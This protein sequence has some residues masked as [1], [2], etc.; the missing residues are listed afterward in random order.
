N[1]SISEQRVAF[2]DING[3]GYPD[4][5]I[6]GHNNAS[7]KAHLN[8]IDK[9]HLL[10]KINTPLGSGFEIDYERVGNTYNQPQS[11]WVFS[12]L[13][14]HDGFIADN[15]YGYDETLTTIIYEKGYHDR[16]ERDFYGFEKVRIEQRF[17]D[18][19]ALLYRY[20]VSEYHNKNYYLKGAVKKTTVYTG[21]EVVLNMSRSFYNLLDPESPTVNTNTNLDN[22]YLQVSEDKLDDSRIFPAI[23][24]TINTIYEGGQ[25]LDLVQEFKAYNSNGNITNY[26]NYGEGYQDAYKTIISYGTSLTY[27]AHPTT[28]E[29]YKNIGNQL[30]RKR[31]ANY[32]SLGQLQMITTH[33]GNNETNRISYEY[34][35][36][37]NVNKINQ[38]DNLNTA[39]AHF[40]QNIVYDSS[41]HTFPISFSDSFTQQS[42]ANYNYLFGTPVFIT[43]T[44]GNSIR[45]R[46]DNRGRVIEVTGPYELENNGWTIRKQYKD[47]GHVHQQ[48]GTAGANVYLIS[49]AKG[50]FKAVNPGA[51]QP[52]NAQHY[53]LTRHIDPS[54]NNNELL[55]L[56]IVDGNGQAIQLKKTHF[57]NSMKWMVNG[58]EEKDA[59]GRVV[60]SYLP[61]V[62]PSY[63]QNLYTLSSAHLSYFAQSPNSFPDPVEMQYDHRNRKISI[64]QPGEN[65]H[66]S[67][68]Y[69]IYNGMFTTLVT[70]E[71]GQTQ[72]SFTDLRG[73]NRKTIQNDEITTEFYYNTINELIKV[74]NTKGYETFYEYDLAGRRLTEKHPDRG[75]TK[76]SYNKIGLPLEKQ[77]SNLL[78]PEQTGVIEYKYHFHRLVEINYPHYP[79]NNVKY[80]YGINL[81][82]SEGAS[83]HIGRM[84][85]QE[86]AT[87]IQ[88]FKYGK[89]GEVIENLRSIAVAGKKSYWFKTQWE[90][91]SWNR[92]Q[93]ITYPDGEIVNYHYNLAGQLHGLARQINGINTPDIIK[94]IEYT[95]YGERAIVNYGNGTK[96]LYDYDLRRRMNNLEHQFTSFDIEKGY[97]YD[98]LSN[99]TSISTINAT[100]PTLGKLGGTINHSYNYDNYNRLVVA[101]GNYVGPGD[102][103]PDLLRH[104]YSLEMEYNESHSIISKK[105]YHVM[106]SIPSITGMISNPIPMLKTSYDLTYD[107]YATGG[108]VI[109][110]F[111][112]AQP[113]APRTI[114][115]YPN[116]DYDDDPT[117]LRIKHHSII[118]DANGNMLETKQRIADPNQPVGFEDKTIRKNLWDEEDR[119]R[120]VDLNPEADE[121]KPEVAVYTYDANGERSIKYTPGRVDSRYSAKETGHGKKLENIF[122]P[123]PLITV[124]ALPLPENPQV[125]LSIGNT[126]VKYTKHYYIGTER[127]NSAL[128]TYKNLGILCNTM[129]VSPQQIALMDQKV[130]DASEAL[131]ENYQKFDKI[132]EIGPAFLY[133]DKTFECRPAHDPKLY[134]SY[135]YHPDHTSTALSTGFGKFKLYY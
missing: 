6:K 91:D 97:T 131:I 98:A 60:K 90:Y 3:D 23:V 119:L 109:D 54:N 39:G 67:I 52:I 37:G 115:E 51:S 133:R 2:N 134:D 11:K 55:T 28:I 53:A 129:G 85:L 19:E 43:D 68:E 69:D 20:T 83:N 66:T 58:Y 93:E 111:G 107:D 42:S 13:R 102:T 112:Y 29:V 44:N 62:Q 86:D 77:T 4:L 9:S 14:T 22:V 59:F 12:S 96:T 117:D 56:S 76:F 125:N 45:T 32:T 121:D 127:I 108:N 80:T 89:L 105:Q 24:K 94:N 49:N 95:N 132:T 5:L 27:R 122:Y 40:T 10:R 33:L 126:L 36:Y 128:G 7:V 87:G 21:D 15:D 130:M 41:I 103:T 34:D 75:V 110:G 74:K 50:K 71:L 124:R 64:Q 123:S 104:E 63:P 26:I 73:R 35:S 99:I 46:I 82:S 118:Y 106:G 81:V 25:G 72:E 30:L 135:W 116:H 88:K 100:N 47:E 8:K 16:R 48:I 18:N 101:S 79:Q 57:S 38:L 70:N 120:A 31:E 1:G 17:P 65:N 78:Q 113:H 92:I 114:M 61:A 84:I